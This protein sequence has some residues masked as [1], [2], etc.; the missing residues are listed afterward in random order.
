M[1]T[2]PL[3]IR[4]VGG[5]LLGALILVSCAMPL[6]TRGE[7][8]AMVALG[9]RGKP[10][11]FGK[12][13]PEGYDCSGLTKVAYAT[14]GIDLIHSAKYIAYD[15]QYETIET[16]S[17]MIPGDLI[18]FDT[19]A[20]SDRYDHVGIWLGMNRFVHASSSEMVIMVSEYDDH[21]RERFSLG[22]RIVNPY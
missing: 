9:H 10:Y 21:W 14:H 4:I 13:G 15:D 2:T 7:S 12:A 6:Y 8:A 20:D 17:A 19:V 22:K 1:K 16:A 5:L 11:I 18:F 3:F